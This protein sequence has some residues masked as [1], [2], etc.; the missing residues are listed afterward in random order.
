MSL[1]YNEIKKFFADKL[2]SDSDGIGRVESA[3]FH[4]I[5]KAYLK[6]VEDGEKLRDGS[7]QRDS[8]GLS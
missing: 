6:G 4:S 2:S 7:L 8:I 5:E 3:F 1:D